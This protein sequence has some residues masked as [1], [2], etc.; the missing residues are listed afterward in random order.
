[1]AGRVVQ[2]HSKCFKCQDAATREIM[3]HQQLSP[4]SQRLSLSL[5]QCD[6]RLYRPKL[7]LCAEHYDQLFSWLRENR[8]FRELKLPPIR[9]DDSMSF[10]K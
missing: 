4:G 10:G 8:E 3:V 1:M 7:K 6:E 5:P 2:R 9:T